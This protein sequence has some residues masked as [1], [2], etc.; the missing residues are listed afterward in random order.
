MRGQETTF[1]PNTAFIDIYDRGIK[2]KNYTESTN[3]Y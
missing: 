1:P 3:D 2:L